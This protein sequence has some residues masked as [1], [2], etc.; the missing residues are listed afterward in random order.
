MGPQPMALVDEGAVDVGLPLAATAQDQ[1]CTGQARVRFHVR[2]HHLRRQALEQEAIGIAAVLETHMAQCHDRDP[3]RQDERMAG[4]LT[5]T[6]VAEEAVAEATAT[7]TEMSLAAVAEAG[8]EFE[9]PIRGHCGA[10]LFRG[11]FQP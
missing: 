7:M 2:G 4:G 3:L 10:Q 11:E 8:A 6:G 5:V 1:T 9:E